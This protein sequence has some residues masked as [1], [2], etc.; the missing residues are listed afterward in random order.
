M[1]KRRPI[2]YR[3]TS[4]GC[5]EITS[6]ITKVKGYTRIRRNGKQVLAH[7]AAYEDA[8]GPIPEGMLVCHKCDNRACVN[9]DHFFLGT[10]A[11]NLRDM[12][13][14][15]RQA[16]HELHGRSKLTEADVVYIRSVCKAG[17]SGRG[18]T[19]PFSQHG[20][21]RT[22]GVTPSL[23]GSIVSGRIWR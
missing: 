5:I 7:R 4:T 13:E 10:H 6:H 22:F 15:N 11:D 2:E 23:I 16:K 20:L 17:G 21:A 9:P 18:K 1:S 19:Q 3:T 14:K 8:F 12:V